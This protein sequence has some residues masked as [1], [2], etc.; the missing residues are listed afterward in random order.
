[1]PMSLPTT[2]L[3]WKDPERAHAAPTNEQF[4]VIE[5]LFD[6]SH[7]WRYILKCRDCG[8]EYLFEFYEEIDW[9]G[10]ND[11]TW[12]TYVPIQSVKQLNQMKAAPAPMQLLEFVPRLQI[13]YPRGAT[14]ARVKWM[15]RDVAPGAC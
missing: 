8:A 14:E 9:E 1:M 10:G 4:E 15:G 6:T 13:D 11:P 3:L 2:C 7:H 5:T 12:I